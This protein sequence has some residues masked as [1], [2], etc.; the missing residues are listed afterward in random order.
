MRWCNIR[1]I[2]VRGFA[3]FLAVGWIFSPS[4]VQTGDPCAY[5]QPDDPHPS[6]GVG[7]KGNT[8]SQFSC[9]NALPEFEIWYRSEPT[10]NFREAA[11]L[12]DRFYHCAQPRIQHPWTPQPN[13]TALG[14]V[15]CGGKT[16]NVRIPKE[17]LRQTIAHIERILDQGH[18]RYPFPLDFDHGHLYVPRVNYKTVYERLWD[19]GNIDLALE[20]ILADRHLK[21]LFHTQELISPRSPPRKLIGTYEDDPALLALDGS[22]PRTLLSVLGAYYGAYSF[23][24]MAHPLGVFELQD[25]TRV[26]FSFHDWM[27]LWPTDYLR[28]LGVVLV[29]EELSQQSSPLLSAKIICAATCDFRRK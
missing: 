15:E 13:E 1:I 29:K 22:P 5:C 12:Y 28:Q 23:Q 16:Y 21:V 26:D 25:G 19:Q 27:R 10:F 3:I 24:F 17:F 8:D 11:V 14:N 20:G 18:A 2:T 9:G 4:E 7:D 6:G